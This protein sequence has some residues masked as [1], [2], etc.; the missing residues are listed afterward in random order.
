MKTKVVVTIVLEV[1]HEKH[2]PINN[3]EY[4]ARNDLHHAETA[5]CSVDYGH[6]RVR[7][8]GRSTET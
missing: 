6:Y 1:E 3:I 8:I 2:M 5:G 7:E 4:V